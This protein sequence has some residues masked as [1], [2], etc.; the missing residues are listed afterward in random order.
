MWSKLCQQTE[1]DCRL[2][3]AIL[4][5]Q[6]C[7]MGCSQ[8][9]A[10]LQLYNI[11][12]HWV[13][14]TNSQLILQTKTDLPLP[15]SKQLEH[16]LNW[17]TLLPRW[18]WLLLV[19]HCSVIEKSTVLFTFS[20]SIKI[21]FW[22]RSTIANHIQYFQRLYTTSQQ[23]HHRHPTSDS[24][25][26]WDL[27]FV[28]RF[29]D[30]HISKVGCAPQKYVPPGQTV[31]TQRWPK[32]L[33]RWKLLADNDRS[34]FTESSPV[35][36]EFVSLTVQT[37]IMYV[38]TDRALGFILKLQS[39]ENGLQCIKYA[40]CRKETMNSLQLILYTHGHKYLHFPLTIPIE[41]LNN[42]YNLCKISSQLTNEWSSSI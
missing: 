15:F 1:G 9:Q 13:V 7:Q 34:T 11:K 6:G 42:Q 26:V 30:M 16:S 38:V 23:K 35:K 4:P 36:L 2:L 20:Q 25:Y 19:T 33:W 32:Y 12:R 21:F 28:Q 22:S 8:L 10:I 31:N 27:S 17:Q 24:L 37:N 3:L 5:P 40:C 39:P 18:H 41:D 29:V 14:V